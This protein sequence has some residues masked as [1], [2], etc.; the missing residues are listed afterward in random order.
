MATKILLTIDHTDDRHP[1]KLLSLFGRL[2]RIVEVVEEEGQAD[3]QHKAEDAAK[4]QIP[5]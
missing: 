3:S 5:P 1:Y 4:H 2:Q